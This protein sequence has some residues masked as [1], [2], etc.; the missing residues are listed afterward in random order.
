MQLSVQKSVPDDLVCFEGHFPGNPLV[1]GALL[2]AWAE[3]LVGENFQR[4]IMQV[5]QVKF[6]SPV[7]PSTTLNFVFDFKE[8]Q[9]KL[10]FEITFCE[11]LSGPQLAAKGVFLTAHQLGLSGDE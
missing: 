11:T 8:A 1:P 2:L 3:A 4:R 5:K 10:S 6:L 9:E 7:R